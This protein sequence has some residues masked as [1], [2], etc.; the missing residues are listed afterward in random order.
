MSEMVQPA[1]NY[2]TPIPSSITT[3]D[4]VETRIGKLEFFDGLPNQE[5]SARVWDNLDFMRGVEVFL[6]GSHARNRF[7]VPIQNPRIFPISP[8][9]DSRTT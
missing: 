8:K 3:P 9:Q 2:N 7:E 4:A 5:T 6:N 1:P